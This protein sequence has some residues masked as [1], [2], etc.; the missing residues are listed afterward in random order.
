MAKAR[1]PR[2]RAIGA[3]ED[4]ATTVMP[5]SNGPPIYRYLSLLQTVSKTEAMI[6]ENL[7]CGGSYVRK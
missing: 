6:Q 4:S 3:N 1:V 7:L 2:G 5:A